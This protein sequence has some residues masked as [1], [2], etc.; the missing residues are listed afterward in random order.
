MYLQKTKVS[1]EPPISSGQN[2][3][4]GFDWTVIASDLGSYGAAVLEKLLTKK[5]CEEMAAL[6]PEEEHFRSHII[7]ARHGFG[8]E[9]I[10]ISGIRYRSSL[11]SYARRCTRGW[12]PSLTN[13]MRGWGS[14]CDIPLSM[15]SF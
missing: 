2:R 11:R 12:R 8:K 6:Y 4:T 5:E 14:K 1:P 10:D 3:N 9:N 7:M 13:G 15:P